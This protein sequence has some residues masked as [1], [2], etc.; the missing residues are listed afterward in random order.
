MSRN[1]KGARLVARRKANTAARQNGGG[2]PAQT[3]PKHGKKNA[4]WQ[5]G[6]RTYRTFLKGKPG[7]RQQQED[8]LA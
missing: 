6:D 1:S 5:V 2:G 7:K 8:S 4:W 3:T